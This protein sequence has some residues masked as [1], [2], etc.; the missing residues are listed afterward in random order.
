[1]RLGVVLQLFTLTWVFH[2]GF[3]YCQKPASVSVGAIFT[4]NSVIGK[5][6]SKAIEAAVSDVNSDPRILNGTELR[7]T[8]DDA[9]SSVFLGSVEGTYL[10]ALSFCIYIAFSESH[11]DF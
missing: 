3:V 8:T 11:F 2:S 10:R 6:A 4:H 1:M 5:V 9:N 7:I